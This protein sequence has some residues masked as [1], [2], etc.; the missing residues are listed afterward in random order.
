MVP[1]HKEGREQLAACRP[2]CFNGLQGIAQAACN[3]I[4][5]SVFVSTQC[6]HTLL[7]NTKPG[8]NAAIQQRGEMDDIGPGR[9]KALHACRAC[10]GAL[11]IHAPCVGAFPPSSIGLNMLLCSEACLATS[12]SLQIEDPISCLI[13]ITR[14]SKSSFAI[15]RHVKFLS[16]ESLKC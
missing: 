9:L 16:A 11:L 8:V 4:E 15:S 5:F 13:K 7:D 2:S 1:V 6:I 10:L 12:T 3:F 14:Q